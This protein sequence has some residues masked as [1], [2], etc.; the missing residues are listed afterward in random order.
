VLLRTSTVSRDTSVTVL[1]PAVTML[2]PVPSV[3]LNSES[4]T[5]IPSTVEST[6]TEVT[7]SPLPPDVALTSDTATEDTVPPWTAV[8]SIAAPVLRFN[9]FSSIVT[10][11]TEPPTALRAI[12][13]PSL[14]SS[15]FLLMSTVETL[16]PSKASIDT[17]PAF[18]VPL[19][20]VIVRSSTSA[21][22]RA[23][24][25]TAVP[26]V[27]LMGLV[28]TLIS[29]RVDDPPTSITRPAAESP[30]SLAVTLRPE[31]SSVRVGESM[32]KAAPADP[33][34]R[35]VLTSNPSM[36]AVA[37]AP[38]STAIP[39]SP[40]SE[41]SFVVA[42]RSVIDAESLRVTSR[43]VAAVLPLFCCSKT[44]VRLAELPSTESETA[45]PLIRSV[46]VLLTTDTFSV[47]AL[48]STVTETPLLAFLI[49]LFA[50]FR[51]SNVPLSWRTDTASPETFRIVLFRTVM[52]RMST[53]VAAGA[54][55]PNTDK[56]VS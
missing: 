49:V 25:S 34:R 17:A 36:L 12:A 19:I 1:V 39:F 37:E 13:S 7:A 52:L 28:L 46:R 22:P 44:S 47:D 32:A 38:V 43:P 29:E 55:V 6:P 11:D 8:T 10:S 24:R 56:P 50:M 45:D 48:P 41:K 3:A 4:L 53:P 40:V 20:P 51:V 31:I 54:S 15:R 30:R 18:A 27:A 35:L 33:L 42:S 26:E 14:A 16:E 23:V 21:D 9:P 2:T 5:S